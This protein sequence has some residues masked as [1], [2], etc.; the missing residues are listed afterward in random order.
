MKRMVSGRHWRKFIIPSLKRV[1]GRDCNGIGGRWL[2]TIFLENG[3]IVGKR[4]ITSTLVPQGTALL[5]DFR[6]LL[7][8]NFGGIDLVVDPYSSAKQATV[9]ITM[10]AM[11]DL[12]V[13]HA[14]AFNVISI[15]SAP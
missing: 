2:R 14:T 11:H 12:A 7:V 9:E 6:Q 4:V 10:H 13:R 3:Q 8:A 15:S 1:C 5:G